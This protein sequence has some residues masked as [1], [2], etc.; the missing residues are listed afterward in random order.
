MEKVRELRALR[1]EMLCFEFKK[2]KVSKIRIKGGIFAC[3]LP[4]LEGSQESQLTECFLLGA[5]IF[6][7]VPRSS[8][9]SRSWPFCKE[10]FN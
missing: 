7:A 5:L 8:Y 9:L 3:G 1:R 2:A 4:E 6:K 10:W